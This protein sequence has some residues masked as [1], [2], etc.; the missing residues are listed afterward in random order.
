MKLKPHRMNLERGLKAEFDLPKFED[1]QK[2]E[3]EEIGLIKGKAP[4]SIQEWRVAKSIMRM[5]LDFVFQYPINGGHQVGGYLIDFVV[6]MPWPQPLEVQSIHWH[7][8]KYSDNERLRAKVIE[9]IF[10]KKIRYVYE[11]SLGSDE[12]A[13][14]HVKKALYG[15]I[16]EPRY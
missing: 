12:E 7:T 1:P 14:R 4:G 5:G 9:D 16:M 6:I 15:P 10:K 8:G 13:Y 11:E 3:E 2:D